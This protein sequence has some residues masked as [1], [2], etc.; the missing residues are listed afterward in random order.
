MAAAMDANQAGTGPPILGD[1]RVRPVRGIEE[2]RRRDRLAAS[3]HCPGFKGFCGRAL[4]HAAAADGTWPAPVGWQAGAF[5]AAV[6]DAWLGWSAAQRHPRLCLVAGNSRF[7]VPDRIPNL[8]SRVLALGLRRLSR[9]MQALHGRP[10]LL[11]GTFADRPR[12]AGTCRRAANRRPLG[13]TRGCSRVPGGLPRWVPNGRSR[14]VCVFGLSGAAPE[15]L[16]DGVPEEAAQ[17]PRTEAPPAATLR[18]LRDFFEEAA[19]FRRAR[20]QRYGL[21]CC[22]TIAVAARMAGY[23]G[24]SAFAGFAG[25]PDD[26]QREAAGAFRSPGRGR[27]T[28]PAEPTFRHIFPNLDPDALDE[29]L[30]SRARHVGDGGPAAMDGKDIRGASKRIGDRRL[31]TAAAVGRCSGT[32]LGQTRT[33]EKSSETFAVRSLSRQPGLSGRTVTLDAMHSQQETAGILRDECGAGYVM[34]AVKDSRPTMHDGLKAIDRDGS[35]RC[36][37]TL[38]KGHGRIGSR[39]CTAVDPSSPE[40]DD[41]CDLCGR[42]QAVRTERRTETLKT[43]GISGE[44]C[45]ALTSLDPRKA[46]ADRLPGLVRGHWHIENE[47]LHYTT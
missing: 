27:W 18:G 19:D 44:T 20:G 21:A 1:V 25:L 45:Y 34:T 3:R 26:G 14:E 4:R 15:R 46:G 42:R 43:G 31:M 2:Q 41:A 39:R 23:R 47:P 13:F 29:A 38:E 40:R 22:L 16:S 17:I 32:V 6:R 36:H 11:C 5:R 28:V 12:F 30:R 7:P 10:V 35:G 24:V 37:E 33:P 9:D 8:A